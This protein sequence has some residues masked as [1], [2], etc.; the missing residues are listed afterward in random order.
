MLCFVLNVLALCQVCS[1]RQPAEEVVK[2]VAFVW[3]LSMS[4][5]TDNSTLLVL[6]YQAVRGAQSFAQVQLFVYIT[7]IFASV[8]YRNVYIWQWIVRRNRNAVF[9]TVALLL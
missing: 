1:A 4:S 7:L 8:I 2:C 9:L 6:P 3:Q 5:S